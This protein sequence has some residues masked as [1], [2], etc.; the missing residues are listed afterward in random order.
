[1]AQ[2]DYV[3]SDHDRFMVD[4]LGG[5]GLS[6]DA[7][8]VHPND[9]AIVEAVDF[10]AIEQNNGVVTVELLNEF[11][12]DGGMDKFADLYVRSHIWHSYRYGLGGSKETLRSFLLRCYNKARM[13]HKGADVCFPPWEG[14]LVD[15]LLGYD[16]AWLVSVGW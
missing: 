5:P 4:V 12:F 14:N 3:G 11:G 9:Y 7:F 2:F 10:A 6:I 16:M 13:F 15:Y 8:G 1:M